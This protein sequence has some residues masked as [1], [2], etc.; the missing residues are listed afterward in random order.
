MKKRA[1][2]KTRSNPGFFRPKMNYNLVI[3]LK[4][5]NNAIRFVRP[6]FAK[7]A[8][9]RMLNVKTI[10][11][12]AF[13]MLFPASINIGIPLHRGWRSSVLSAK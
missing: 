6:Y 3:R 5:K 12:R 10:S 1:S 2:S 8:G 13:A 9:R 11:F 4:A 7:K